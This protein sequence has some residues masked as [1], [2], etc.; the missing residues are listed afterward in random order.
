MVRMRISIDAGSGID[1]TGAY[2]VA[3]ALENVKRIVQVDQGNSLFGTY[4]LYKGKKSDKPDRVLLYNSV[5]YSNTTT[6]ARPS[7]SFTLT[8]LDSSNVKSLRMSAPNS[9]VIQA[10]DV[11]IGGRSF[12]VDTC[13]LGKSGPVYEKQNVKGDSVTFSVKASE[14]LLVYL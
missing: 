4:F 3:T 13:E 2:F 14:A 6:D 8:G 12:V 9:N 10:S 5:Y 7:Q 1:P 11:T